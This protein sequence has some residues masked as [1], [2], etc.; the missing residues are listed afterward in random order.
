MMDQ[1]G[2]GLY[3]R[4]DPQAFQREQNARVKGKD[5]AH[6]A[7]GKLARSVGITLSPPQPHPSGIAMHYVLGVLPGALYAVLRHR[8]AG[9][10]AGR[11]CFS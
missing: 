8:V 4:E 1:V 7:T 10:G 5:V 6:V 3:L 2:W 9:P 11:A